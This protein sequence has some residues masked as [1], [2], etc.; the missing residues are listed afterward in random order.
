MQVVNRNLLY[1]LLFFAKFSR[2]FY[3]EDNYVGNLRLMPDKKS[4]VA[5]NDACATGDE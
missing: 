3:I 5:G 4:D 1:A 2:I